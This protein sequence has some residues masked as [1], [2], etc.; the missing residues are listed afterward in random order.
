MNILFNKQFYK[1]Y[2]IYLIPIG[3]S[4]LFF[5]KLGDA[6]FW[7]DELVTLNTITTTKIYNYHTSQLN[8]PLYFLL[9]RL[10][11]SG[12]SFLKFISLLLLLP[13]IFC[14]TIINKWLQVLQIPT[15]N[16]N[17]LLSDYY[18]YNLIYNLDTISEASVRLPSA[19]FLTAA[20]VLIFDYFKK[21]KLIL[22]GVIT[23]L[24]IGTNSKIIYYAQEARPY[25]LLILIFMLLLREFYTVY[26]K[27]LTL[28]NFKRLIF[29]NILMMLTHYYGLFVVCSELLILSVKNKKNKTFIVSNL[30]ALAIVMILYIQIYKVS[31][32]S[33]MSVFGEQSFLDFKKMYL[34][35]LG[36]F[37]GWK[38][39]VAGTLAIVLKIFN[40]QTFY[41]ETIF[42]KAFLFL[43]SVLASIWFFVSVRPIFNIRYTI[44]LIPLQILIITCIC[45]SISES[46]FIF[47][48]NKRV[49]NIAIATVFLMF[50][51]S[52]V[53]SQWT[54]HFNVFNYYETQKNYSIKNAYVAITNDKDFKRDKFYILEEYIG[55][56]FKYYE[57]KYGL[58]SMI[59]LDP[60]ISNLEKE[61]KASGVLE[62]TSDKI[63]YY[64][65]V[66]HK[67]T[68]QQ[69]EM[70]NLTQFSK[71]LI[72][73]ENVIEVYK[74]IREN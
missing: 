58:R 20:N 18:A 55:N 36:Y 9:T 46:I 11:L 49:K 69:E 25:A 34:N 70:I 23:S 74:L 61:I 54:Y 44:F 47:V 57:Q 67:E 52:I 13:S 40:K 10:Y 6:S 4:F 16:F 27:E 56:Y 21:N 26:N 60:K 8:P 50:S 15:L 68:T 3:F 30:I 33:R 7:F 73:K 14:I 43:V 2:L 37:I 35:A 12:V 64:I 5:W 22:V 28:Q 41:T 51:L 19:V 31:N 66:R 71:K 39:F 65:R 45:Y 17:N 1:N 32:I 59:Y 72:F 24:L 53:A 48:K 63:I 38:F 29:Y 62:K 42:L